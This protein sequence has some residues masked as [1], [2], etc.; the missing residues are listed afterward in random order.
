MWFRMEESSNQSQRT[1]THMH[2]STQD[3]MCIE[4]IY[5]THSTTSTI[6]GGVYRPVALIAFTLCNRYHS[7]LPELCQ[8]SESRLGCLLGTNS[9][10]S[11]QLPSNQHSPLRLTL[12]TPGPLFKR[13]LCFWFLSL[14]TCL[15]GSSVS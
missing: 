4:S 13:C 6:F 2:T 3:C 12:L 10:S 9:P 14:S 1:H 5:N 15:Q 7:P 11:P 8:L